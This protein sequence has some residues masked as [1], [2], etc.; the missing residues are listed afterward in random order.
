MHMDDTRVT[1]PQCRRQD[2]RVTDKGLVFPHWTNKGDLCPPVEAYPPAAPVVR[3][4]KKTRR[5]REEQE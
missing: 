5:G 4:G 1:C 3:K 2:L